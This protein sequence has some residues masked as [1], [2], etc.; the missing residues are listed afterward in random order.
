[1]KPCFKQVDIPLTIDAVQMA[2]KIDTIIICSGDSDY[3][4]LVKHLKA[5]GLR[6]EIAS[7][8]HSTAQALIDIVDWHHIVDEKDC[9]DYKPTPT[10]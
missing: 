4:E 2:D 7:V 3:V 9:F 6:V 10:K 8:E 5:K 1:M